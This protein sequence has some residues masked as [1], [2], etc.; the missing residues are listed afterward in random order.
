MLLKL[1]EALLG[2]AFAVLVIM[3]GSV[4]FKTHAEESVDQVRIRD[5]EKTVAPFAMK[6]ED[7]EGRLIKLE[8]AVTGFRNDSDEIKWWLRGLGGAIALAVLERVLRTAG[9]K[10]GTKSDGMGPVG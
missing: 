4:P 6:L 10:L 2:A 3:V 8:D 5:L 9:I 7:H 1:R